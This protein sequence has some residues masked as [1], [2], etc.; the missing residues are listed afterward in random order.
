MRL[1]VPGG[2]TVDAAGVTAVGVLPSHR[3]RGVMTAMVESQLNDFRARGE[4]VACLWTTEGAIYGRFGWGMAALA[5]DM[6]LPREWGAF[7]E[8]VD[9]PGEVRLVSH[10]EAVALFPGIYERVLRERP[11]MFERT[12]DW[13]AL[14]S[15]SDDPERHG[16]GAVMNRALLEIDGRPEAYALYR[17]EP[18]FDGR[19]PTGAVQVVEAVGATATAT[20]AL[21]RYLLDID[22]TSVTRADKLPVDH[23]LLMLLLEPRRMRF[24]LGDSLWV[25]LVDLPHALARRVTAGQDNVVLEVRD[26]WCPWNAGRWRVGGGGA[27]RTRARAELALDVSAL[28]SVYLGGFTF[29]E[30]ADSLRVDELAPGAVARVDA[31]F[32][33]GKAPWCPEAF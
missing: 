11:G 28:G 27:E 6:A 31:L 3:R 5:G 7:A 22:W 13:W 25:R 12:R 32:G 9:P 23:P 17:I 10:D 16:G 19:V 18:R 1:S 29:R 14:R 33:R 26:R 8:P 24:R 15:L 20:S 30:L 21:W 2:S 4:S